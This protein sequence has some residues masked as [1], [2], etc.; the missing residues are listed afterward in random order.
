[1]MV[2]NPYYLFSQIGINAFKNYTLK[3]R[4]GYF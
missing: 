4:M 3:Y 1:M 2:K